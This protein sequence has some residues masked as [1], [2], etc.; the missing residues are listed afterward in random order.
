MPAT[1]EEKT[2]IRTLEI[3]VAEINVSLKFFHKVGWTL[4]GCAIAAVGSLLYVAYRA[5]QVEGAVVTL[6]GRVANIE[7]SLAV[8]EKDFAELKVDLAGLKK[9]TVEMRADIKGQADQSAKVLESLGRIEK[10]LA[11]AQPVRKPTTE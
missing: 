2:T 6:T 11:Q 3:Q 5:G 8:I 10:A 9:D 4:A 1:E 7:N